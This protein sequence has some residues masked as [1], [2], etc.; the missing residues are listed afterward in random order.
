M[1]LWSKDSSRCQA[2][3]SSRVRS[4][5]ID[6][7]GDSLIVPPGVRATIINVLARVL[8]IATVLMI[9]LCVRYVR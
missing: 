3:R 4:Y 8:A 5:G 1:R 2:G 7:V 9:F 6:E